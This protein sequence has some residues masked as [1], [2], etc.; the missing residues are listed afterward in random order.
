MPGVHN[1]LSDKARLVQFSNYYLYS[2]LWGASL[3]NLR[4][5]PHNLIWT[6]PAKGK[7]RTAELRQKP[8]LL[9]IYYPWCLALVLAAFFAASDFLCAPFV[10]APLFAEADRSKDIYITCSRARIIPTL[11]I[12]Y[13]FH[14]CS[15]LSSSP[16]PFHLSQRKPLH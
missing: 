16:C 11:A 8:E 6:I 1:F 12:R 3:R 14:S 15:T 7:K 10:S 9:F 4:I 13:L 2:L 5:Y